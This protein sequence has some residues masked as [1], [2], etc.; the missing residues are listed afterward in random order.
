MKKVIREIIIINFILQSIL[1]IAPELL[2]LIEE[3]ERILKSRV[4]Y[5]ETQYRNRCNS[6]CLPSYL[7]CTDNLPPLSCS[8]D[9]NRTECECMEVKDSKISLV[10]GVV[11][12]PNYSKKNDTGISEMACLVSGM[13]HLFKDSFGFSNGTRWQYVATYNKVFRKFPASPICNFDPTKR[14]WFQTAATGAKNVLILMDNSGSMMNASLSYAKSA[15]KGV[16]ETLTINDWVGLVTFNKIATAHTKSLIRASIENKKIL[17]LAIDSL[18]TLPGTNYPDAFTT[19][20]QLINSTIGKGQYISCHTIIL[21]LTDDLESDDN[22]INDLISLIESL[23][24][25][26]KVNATLISYSFGARSKPSS[27]LPLSCLRNGF[28]EDIP[29]QNN[30]PTE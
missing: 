20:Y 29:S 27:L 14:P 25:E 30:Y 11:A 23:E 22:N 8:R 10:E 24:K 2:N 12:I 13:D 17:N 4:R 1:S 6:P 21:F 26:Y 18:D 3:T 5:L 28:V 19:A 16:V 15:A 9:Y 7:S